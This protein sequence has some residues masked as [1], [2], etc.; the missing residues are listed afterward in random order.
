MTYDGLPEL[1]PDDKLAMDILRE[2]GLDC[3]AAVWNDQSVD[4]SQSGVCVLRSTWDYHEHVDAFRTWVKDQADRLVNSTSLVTW[5]MNKHYL[6]DLERRG[7]DIVPTSFCPR[8]TKI[9]IKQLTQRRGWTKI[10]VKPAVG[11]ATYGVKAFQLPEEWVDAQEHAEL[12]LRTSDVLIQ[13]FL[14]GVADY[15]ERALVFFS[16]QFSHAV[17][18][19]PFQR[20][21]AA[22][23]AGE[24]RVVSTHAER[25]FATNVIQSM[26]ETPIYARVDVVPSEGRPVLLELELIEPSLFLAFD[27][28][29]AARFADAL[30]LLV[31]SR[32]NSADSAQDSSMQQT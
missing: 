7:V 6:L 11:L 2:R 3:G 23:E 12:L 28:A 19:Q 18:K 13:Q 27:P 29:A 24:T 26:R 1:D 10:I 8:G 9:T 22:G 15:G 31:V 14:P 5:N 20:L 21:A 16:G 25:E 30:E 4:W 17:R 32:R